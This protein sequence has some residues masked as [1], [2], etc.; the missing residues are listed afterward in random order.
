MKKDGK[1][2]RGC[3]IIHSCGRKMFLSE[4]TIKKSCV[5]ICPGCG[6]MIEISI[7]GSDVRRQ[8]LQA[9]DDYTES[10]IVEKLK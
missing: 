6:S 10:E 1:L 5:V 7:F 9:L 8:L 2:K 3:I 4:E